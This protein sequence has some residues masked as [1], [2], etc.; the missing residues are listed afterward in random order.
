MSG[1]R[2]GRVLGL[3]PA[4]AGS[5]RLP[6][7]NIR[8][9]AGTT[10]LGRTIHSAR[11]SG[12][13]DRILVS[14]ED[15]EVADIAEG[16]GVELP[17]MRPDYLARDPAGV[18]DVALHVLDELESRGEGYDTLVIL[19]P[20]SPFRRAGD[21][22]GAME[23]YL[24]QEVDF[25]MSVYTATRW[26]LT[27]CPWNAASTLTPNRNSLS[28][29]SWRCS[30]RTGSM[31]DVLFRA[32]GGPGIGGGH[33]ARCLALAQYCTG[34][35]W[36][37]ALAVARDTDLP[38]GWIGLASDVHVLGFD[39]GC[40]DD[41]TAAG[42]LADRLEASWIVADSYAFDDEF[43]ARLAS[44]SPRLLYVDD[45]GERDALA[46][47]ALN[48]NVGADARYGGCYR[49]S[50]RVLLGA[51]YFL[52]RDEIRS[53]RPS[54]E[55]GR[56]VITFGADDSGNMALDFVKLAVDQGIEIQAEVVCTAQGDGLARLRAVTAAAPGT[57]DIHQGPMAIAPIMARAELVVCAGGSTA[58]E[59]ASLGVPSIIVV[60]ADNQRPGAQA[61]AESGVAVLAGD[62]VDALPAAV[63]EMRALLADD[64]RRRNM[65]GLGR[66]LI[67]GRGAGRVVG[68]M[69]A[70]EENRL[71]R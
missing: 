12:I 27:R 64:T 39:A 33:L 11:K 58:C 30:T 31:I 18:V 9:L 54:P 1:G 55:P 59:A 3:I 70:C 4:K 24:D 19:L 47:I 2:P 43:L 66:E 56:V 21:I 20:T 38:D 69:Q 6:R 50:D 28:R 26:P 60:R 35:G 45:L 42:R 5:V 53:Q 14:T 22:T 62:G 67:D 29:N 65:G 49:R 46:E 32:D 25:L 44:G 23:R 10:L 57:W 15:K 63:A 13:C 34:K 37:C 16:A 7:K 41:L 36:S 17:F 61:L 8:P 48:P 51:D 71:S 68:A 52:L 40:V